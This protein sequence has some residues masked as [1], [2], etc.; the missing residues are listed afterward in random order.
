MRVMNMTDSLTLDKPTSRS[1]YSK[2]GSTN[3]FPFDPNNLTETYRLVE[4]QDPA[5]Q[6][7]TTPASW[8]MQ[9]C[10][11]PA[12]NATNSGSAPGSGPISSSQTR[13]GST[14][15]RPSTH[16]LSLLQPSS[17]RLQ[18]ATWHRSPRLK[19]LPAVVFALAFRHYPSSLKGL[20]EAGDSGIEDHQL[21]SSNQTRDQPR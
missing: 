20:P 12:S 16:W 5:T 18:P 10:E 1:F 17:S 15:V 8:I 19:P 7:K 14:H 6:Q 11:A 9:V 4:H 21:D 3:V 2:T 13:Y